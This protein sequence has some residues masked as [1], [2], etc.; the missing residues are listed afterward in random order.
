MELIEK[1]L[2]EFCEASGMKIN[3]DRSRMFCS[4]NIP[5]NIQQDLSNILGIKRAANLGKYLGILMTR[6]CSS[7]LIILVVFFLHFS[8]SHIMFASFFMHF[9]VFSV[10]VSFG[11]FTSFLRTF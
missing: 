11:E 5:Q 9:C 3:L 6:G 1:T 7:N 8:V 10:L 2:H 4:K